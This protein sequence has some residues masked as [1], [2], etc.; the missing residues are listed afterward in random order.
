MLIITI[1]K[2]LNADRWY[3]AVKS[4]QGHQDSRK[5]HLQTLMTF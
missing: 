2:M 4:L 1:Y 3:P 5:K